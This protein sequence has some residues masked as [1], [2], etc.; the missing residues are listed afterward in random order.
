MFAGV[1]GEDSAASTN[2]NNETKKASCHVID[3]ILPLRLLFNS[4]FWT[5][6]SSQARFSILQERTSVQ[7][8]SARGSC[9][10]LSLSS[11]SR[12]TGAAT[13]AACWT[14]WWINELQGTL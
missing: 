12:W 9:T 8:R 10:G 2:L 7:M 6:S 13:G 4:H 3:S 14:G 1:P 5:N 11:G